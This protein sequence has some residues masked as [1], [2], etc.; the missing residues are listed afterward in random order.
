MVA[1]GVRWC[2]P[3]GRVSVQ[4]DR[5]FTFQVERKPYTEAKDKMNINNNSVTN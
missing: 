2:H 3:G 5:K 1:L 4:E